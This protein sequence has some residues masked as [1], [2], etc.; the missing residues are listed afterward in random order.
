MPIVSALA[1]I[2]LWVVAIALVVGAVLGD[3]HPM[4]LAGPGVEAPQWVGRLS[5]HLY[6][7]ILPLAMLAMWARRRA[8]LGRLGMVAALMIA[9]Q[10]VAYAVITIGAVVWGALL[11]RGD[12]PSVVLGPVEAVGVS[13]CYL[14][15]VLLSV[16]FMRDRASDRWVGLLLLV[17]FLASFVTPWLMTVMFTVL[18]WLVLRRG[19]SAKV[20]DADSGAVARAH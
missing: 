20:L 15:V 18:A 1:R 12:L 9:V 6:F 5:I 19:L 8:T 17:G 10:V 7:V 16:A 11:G 2:P 13:L 14:G 3:L 4:L